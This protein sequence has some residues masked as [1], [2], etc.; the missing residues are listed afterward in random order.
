[1][2][3]RSP[4]ALPTL[5]RCANWKRTIRFRNVSLAAKGFVCFASQKFEMA[6]ISSVL[7]FRKALTFIQKSYPFGYDFGDASTRQDCV[8]SAQ[9]VYNR[10]LLQKPTEG[11]L[12]F[13]TLALLAFDEGDDTIDQEKARDLVRLFR[14]DREGNLSMLDFV[15][16]IDS[17]YKEFRMLSASIQNSSQI[18]RAIE[19]IFNVLFYVTVGVIVLA[20]LGL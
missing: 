7:R 12:Q 2:N 16:S 11:L 3:G 1:V 5:F 13:E 15:K 18:D 6:S 4:D 9:D 10:L 14:P 20:A 19:S 8:E 17:V